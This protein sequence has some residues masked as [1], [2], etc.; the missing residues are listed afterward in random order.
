MGILVTAAGVLVAL[1]ASCGGTDEA[2]EPVAL[3]AGSDSVAD[4]VAAPDGA[5][6]PPDAEPDAPF[7][8]PDSNEPNDT[9]ATVIVLKP[10]ADAG[11][12][13]KADG[14]IATPGDVDRFAV[15]VPANGEVLYVRVTAPAV[16]PAAATG[17]RYE[18]RRHGADGGGAILAQGEVPD[19]ASAVDLGTAQRITSP[20]R[21]E[22]VVRGT[23]PAA[24]P[25]RRYEVVVSTLPVADELEP[26]DAMTSAVVR[27]VNAPNGAPTTFTGRVGWVGDQD[28]F[29]VDLPASAGPTV[30]AYRLFPTASGRFPRLPGP[31]DLRLRVM[32]AVTK[33][34]DVA[35]SRVACKTDEAACPKGHGGA[36]AW[37]A[38][39]EAV[40]DAP[41]APLC[42]HAERAEHAPHAKLSNFAGVIPVPPH[43]AT[44]RVYFAM[45]NA[46]GDGADDVPYS[47]EVSWR[48]DPDEAARMSGG[49][50]QPISGFL[51]SDPDGST[52]PAPPAGAT[53]L[54]GT[55][56]YGFGLST[57]LAPTS[58][59]SVRGPDDY[60]AVPS[61][62]D[63]Y[64]LELPS[65]APP[66]DRTWA[67]QWGVTTEDDEAPAHDLAIDAELCDGDVLTGGVCTPVATRKDGGPIRFTY[68]G[69]AVPWPS[70][71]AGA[72][73]PHFARATTTSG[74][75]DAGTF[76]VTTTS[77]AV[78]EG[79][80]CF[81]PRF[82]RG[83]RVV[84]RVRATDRR[85]YGPARYAVRTAYTSYPKSASCPAPVAN[86]DG[87][88][89][90]CALLK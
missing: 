61:D 23:T 75:L 76:E 53:L 31:A 27:G 46:G 68:P 72:S 66:L 18:L 47:L 11:A 55:L 43:A 85:H 78:P 36:G 40:C 6:P 54:A 65:V 38:A 52:Y 84:L 50:E 67:L 60:D 25:R 81:E 51:A 34:A 82:I 9:A 80:L 13:G 71:G 21:Y 41:A 44:Q 88:L 69:T 1:A 33:G 29:A 62:V 87:F 49:V 10:G 45:E 35:A 26:N 48:A 3:D 79:C 63:T 28:W 39:V 32:T 74:S 59:E 8:E 77:T 5:S 57:A 12:E 58:P 56:T 7:A 4:A 64:I 73:I 15:D 20:G 24:E 19:L 17:L 37:V 14:Y 90:G 22:I 30:L 89:P 2:M 16:S 86:G 42:L 70:N 83:G